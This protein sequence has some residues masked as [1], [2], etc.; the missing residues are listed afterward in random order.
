MRR[1]FFRTALKIAWRDARASTGKFLFVVLAVAIG[2]G[3]LTGVRGFSQS[4]AAMLLRE[5]RTVLAGD[6][7]VRTNVVPN[8][9]QLAAFR[10]LEQH[11]VRSTR[12]TETFSMVSSTA[13]DTPIPVTVKAVDPKVY[14]LYGQV[15]LDPPGPL[16]NALQPGSVAISDDLRL[17]LNVSTGG[18]IHVGGGTYRIDAIVISEPDRLIG[19]PGLGPRVLMS[20]DALEKT[21]LIRLGSR[22]QQRILFRT[23]GAMTIGQ[24]RAALKKV[25]PDD[26]ISDYREANQNITRALDF[27]TSFLSLVSLIALI[28]GGVGVATA[29][30]AHLRQ[31]MDSIAVMKCI[32][33]NA[34]QITE[35]YVLQTLLLG[36]LGGLLGIIIGSAV[37]HIFPPIIQRYFQIKAD[38]PWVPMSALQGICTG[39]LTTLLFT[40]PPLLSIRKIRPNLIF[41]RD[42]P[43]VKPSWRDRLREGKA[44]VLAGAV[45]ML[46]IA[47][48]A[49]WLIGGKLQD[50]AR[51]GGY[52][53][54]GLLVSLVLLS[55]VAWVLLRVLRWFIAVTGRALP[56]S[57]RHGIAN[58]YRPGS[59]ATAILTALGVGVMFTLTVYLIQH[60][61]LADLRQTAPPGMANVFLLDVTPDQRDRVINLITHEHGVQH[62][63][64]LVGTVSARL[65]TVDGIRAED[66]MVNGQRRRFLPRRIVT[67]TDRIP[68]DTTVVKGAWWNSKP[69]EPE[70]S[71]SEWAAKFFG[72]KVGSVMEWDAFGR[73]VKTRVVS[74]HRMNQHRLRARLDYFF[75]PGTLD[76]LPAVYY[77]AVRVQPQA[78]PA[79]QRALYTHFPTITVI[80]MADVIERIQDIINQVSLI[81]RFISLFA[82]IA[83][84]TILASS[85]A[86][87]RFRRIREVVIFKTLGATRSRIVQMFSAEFLILGTI[88]GMMGSLLAT[89]FSAVIIKQVLKTD[90]HFDILPEL[91]AIA[92]TAF[93]ASAA[94]WVASYRILGQKPLE[95]L[96]GE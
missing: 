60:S 96:R 67:M 89:G 72:V 47:A 76:G 92:L 50:A 44:V 77:G 62:A 54:G 32:G 91:V 53:V 61:I 24:I 14:P 81:I 55:A 6:V 45:I 17:R 15:T 39:L 79:L 38:V 49:M 27:C 84:A 66:L 43:E 56:A 31:R 10:D 22:A 28:V 90:F 87:T 2:V 74:I 78:V 23:T 19:G 85:V 20:Q 86:G 83:G 30:H 4:L 13:S 46:G 40:L 65:L 94:G 11:G 26:S 75:S 64:E 33:G 1:G 88:A 93:I 12:V 21:E 25:F 7:L 59:Q 52:F 48:L 18:S 71:L 63:P 16:A 34:T 35:I 70:I 3:A 36:V 82:I 95:V 41:R 37:Q 51:V 68:E 57:L 5:A 8:E 9:R 42:M 58:L 73:N 69:P 29:M 80:N